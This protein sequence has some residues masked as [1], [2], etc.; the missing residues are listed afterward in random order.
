M[1]NTIVTVGDYGTNLEESVFN[2]E[3]KSEDESDYVTVVGGLSGKRKVHVV[4]TPLK[5]K[6]MSILNYL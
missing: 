6:V 5:K 4:A 1:T 3:D 2:T